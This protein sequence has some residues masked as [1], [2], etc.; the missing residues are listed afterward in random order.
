M[1][2]GDGAAAFPPEPWALA[3]QLYASVFLVPPAEL[4]ADVLAELPRGHRAF[5]IGR[6]TVIGLAWVDYQPGGVLTYREVLAAVLVRRG[7]RVAPTIVRIWVDSEASLAGGRAL[8]A[9]PK[10]LAR[11]EV[12]GGRFAADTDAGPIGFGAA[13]VRAALPGR[14]PVRFRV[15]QHRG[16][17]PVISPVRAT[18]R[19]AFTSAAV[20]LHGDG[21]LGFVAGLRP[22]VSFALRDFRMLFGRTGGQESRG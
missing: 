10:D 15:A 9:I 14:W 2:V 1:S 18:G 17:T 3:G 4:P 8:W 12:Q 16:A 5:R 22:V 21:P 7:L 13:R 6:R 11:L 20:H 19:V